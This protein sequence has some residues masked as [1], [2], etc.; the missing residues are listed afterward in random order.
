[1]SNY[2]AT[3]VS[4]K[5]LRPHTNADRL[6]C[7]NI[8]GN[9]VIVG[10]DTKV[11]DVGLF[12]PLESQ[13]G[14]EFAIANDLIRRKDETGKIVGGMFDENRRVRAQKFRGER[15]EGFFIP[16][17][18]LSSLFEIK[19]LKEGDE[20]TK[21]GDFVI[22]EKYIPTVS[23]QNNGHGNNQKEGRKPRESR[24]IADQFRFHQ[25]TSQLG[26]NL[27]R[28]SPSDFV[29]LTWKLH[30]TSAIAAN[31]LVK[32]KLNLFE[33]I[34]KRFGVAVEDKKYDMVYASRRVIKNEFESEKNHYYKTDIWSDVGKENFE[35][36][37]R[38]GETV[39]YEIVGFTDG[40]SYIQKDFDYKC[41]PT[42]VYDGPHQNKAYI[43]RI[44]QTA[45]DGSVV[46]LPWNQV[47]VRS[48]QLGVDTVPEISSGFAAG[49][50]DVT[51][52]IDAW[53]QSFLETLKKLYVYDQ[54]SQF[55]NNK[56]PEEGIVVRIERGVG[57]EAYKLKSFRFL[58]YETK[59]LDKEETNIED[60]Q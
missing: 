28:I 11:G 14:K 6:I 2:A 30:G 8:F 26:K 24:I 55:C 9:N 15:S 4:I 25:D 44:T 37:L 23:K 22:S 17:E 56:V 52:D 5:N 38:T 48:L 39:Y 50:S 36:R 60:Q 33:R 41:D 12:F 51:D 20:I 18:S 10:K 59:A 35:G 7:T 13:I 43:Y 21:L 42:G 54:D 53:R 45:L 16:I 58:E 1:M 47:V 34:V 32:K 19:G 49:M 3:V 40:G 27:H 57:F 46:E 31:A 29:V